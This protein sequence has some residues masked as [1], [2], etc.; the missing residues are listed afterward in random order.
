MIILT[1]S[2]L[3]AIGLGNYKVDG[4]SMITS[5]FNK[6]PEDTFFQIK[7]I[8]ENLSVSIDKNEVSYYYYKKWSAIEWHMVTGFVCDNITELETNIGEKIIFAQSDNSLASMYFGND[9]IEL[10]LKYEPTATTIQQVMD[11]G[12]VFDTYVLKIMNNVKITMQ[13]IEPIEQ[14][15]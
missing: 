1:I 3:N 7:N 9:T 14:Q 10:I 4:E 5:I 6:F 8:S 15:K 13:D 12:V 2:D 11:R